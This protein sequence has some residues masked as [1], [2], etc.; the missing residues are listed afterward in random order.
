MSHDRMPRESSSLHKL[1]H[2]AT[3]EPKLLT[4]HEVIELANHVLKSGEH[5]TE[6][7]VEIAKRALHNPE[8]MEAHDITALGERTLAK[9]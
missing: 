6:K 3:H 2:R 4:A 1:A 7:E 5:P 8:G 9:S